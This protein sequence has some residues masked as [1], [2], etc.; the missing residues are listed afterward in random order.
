[1]VRAFVKLTV[2]VVSMTVSVS[3]ASAQWGVTAL[4]VGEWDT[5]ETLVLLAGLSAGPGG[6]GLSPLVGAQASWVRFETGDADVSVRT[7]RPYG[8]ARYGFGSGSAYGTLGYAFQS[9]SEDIEGPIGVIGSAGDTDDG[10]VVSGGVEYWGTGGPLGAQALASYNLGGES[11]WTRGRV[12]TRVSSLSS[13]GQV[14]LGGEVAYLT[15]DGYSIVQP[16]GVVAWHRST[17]GLILSA[18]AG[19]K[20]PDEG[21]NATYVKAEVVLPFH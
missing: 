1:M 3:H 14:R 19:V 6:S 10:A 12:T 18:G 13:G 5:N 2:A 17:N 15:G 20:I 8:G 7:I 21:D 16:G 9:R 11:L 4:G